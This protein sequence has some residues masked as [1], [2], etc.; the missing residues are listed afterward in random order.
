MQGCWRVLLLSLCLWPLGLPAAEVIEDFAVELGLGR[1]GM[2]TVTERITVQAEGREI[3]RGIYRDIPVRYSLPWGLVRQTPIDKLSATRNG[4]PESV[5]R[6]R[7]G[8]FQRFYLGSP[9]ILLEPGRYTYELRYRVDPQ[10]I[11]RPALT[12]CTGMSPV[13]AGVSLSSRPPST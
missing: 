10:L 13:M 4:Q 9:N 8:A 12:S 2:L 5:K 6:E 1:D 7:Q 3:R 11:A